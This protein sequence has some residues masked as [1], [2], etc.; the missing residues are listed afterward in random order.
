[1]RSLFKV[2]FSLLILALILIGVSYSMLRAEGVQTGSR[3]ERRALASET[4]VLARGIEVVELSGPI[5]LT[6]R[7]GTTASLTVKGEERLLPNIDSFQHENVLHIGTKG[8]VLRHRQPLQAVLV[9]P[10]LSRLIVDGSG[11]SVISGLSGDAISLM[12]S[13]SGSVRFNGRYQRVDAA[14]RG[15]GDLEL[16]I[17]NS[18]DVTLLQESSGNI[19][20][21]GSTHKLAIKKEGSGEL[22]AR[23]LRADAVTLRQTGSGDSV[24][25][26]R[27]TVAIDMSGS[28]D[29][30]VRGG[31]RVQ[32]VARTGSGDVTFRD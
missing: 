32:S 23:H 3:A 10:A 4:R 20:A 28:G 14:L 17:G 12:A 30:R 1:M 31:P 11:D 26:A 8:M 25:L 18:D 9:L 16:N 13:G 15:S 29:V 24:I 21:L 22:D 19:T 2:A 5:D 27:E 6:L 7:Y